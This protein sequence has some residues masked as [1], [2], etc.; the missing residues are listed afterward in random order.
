MKGSAAK[1][2]KSCQKHAPLHHQPTFSLKPISSPWPF[3]QWGIDIV[4]ELPKAVDDIKY[5]FT[6]TN[7]YTKYVEAKAL[8]YIIATK[9]ESF[10]WKYIILRFGIPYDVVSNNGT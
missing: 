8:V 9:I 2:C 3:T 10:Q 5:L 7:H 4:E 6:T 1:A